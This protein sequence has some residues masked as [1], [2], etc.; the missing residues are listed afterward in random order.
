MFTLKIKT[1]GSAF[2]DADAYNVYGI[3]CPD[4][5]AHEIRRILKDVEEN[6]RWGHT[7]GRILDIN[8]NCVGEWAYE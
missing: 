5:S 4:P 8:G 7:S 1:G 2:M 6:L 3:E